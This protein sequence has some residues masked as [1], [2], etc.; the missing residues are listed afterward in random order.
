MIERGKRV[1]GEG[2]WASHTMLPWLMIAAGLVGQTGVSVFDVDGM[3]QVQ[4]SGRPAL[5]MVE[6]PRCNDAT[7]RDLRQFWDMAGSRFPGALW[8]ATCTPQTTVCAQ[9]G[10][11][12]T[13][14]PIFQAWLPDANA[15][16]PSGS[17]VPYSGA[18]DL[19]GLM[20]WITHAADPTANLPAWLPPE[21]VMRAGELRMTA[22]HA[23]A[24][25]GALE[26]LP[27]LLSSGP[28]GAIHAKNRNGATALSLAADRGHV[29][30]VL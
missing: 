2:A 10:V 12:P 16:P 20:G 19:N 9:L 18:K 27:A 23:A 7:C 6:P 21:A 8:R 13:E 14:W 17:F 22:L 29:K 28:W 3:A 5:L 1:S 24:V 25:E 15:P 4:R 30:V 11:A 26:A